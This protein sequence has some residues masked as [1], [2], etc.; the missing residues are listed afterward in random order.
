[1]SAIEIEKCVYNVHPFF[2]LYAANES[3]EVIHIIKKVPSKGRKQQNGYMGC[4]VRKYG[5]RPKGCQVHR[6]VWECFNGVIPEGKVID[7]INNDKED[8]RICNLQLVTQQQNCKKASKDRDYT[9]VA[10]NHMNKRSVKAINNETNEV[11]YYQTVCMQS[12]NI[13]K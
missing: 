12:N 13:F 4:S 6:F 11:S 5:G 7:H 9:F 3:G 10:K 2:D 1:M 8:N